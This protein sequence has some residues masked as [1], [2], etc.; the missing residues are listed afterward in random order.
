MASEAD[1][2]P[3]EAAIRAYVRE[4]FADTIEDLKRLVRI[5]SVSWPAFDHEP[6]QRTSAEIAEMLRETGIFDLVDVRRAP[7]DVQPEGATEVELGQPAV[8][9][10]RE[11]KNGRPTVLLYAHHDVQPPGDEQ[12][13]ES[14]AFEPNERNGRLYGRGAADDKAGVMSHVGAIRALAD[15]IAADGGDLDLGIALF[16]EG[17]EEWASQSFG[18]FLRENRDVLA[19]D[20]IIVADSGNWDEKTPALTVALR[21]AVAFNLR[22]RTL[23]H[24]SHSGMFGGAVPDAMMATVKLLSTLWDEDGAVA[25]SGLTSADIASPEYD[26]ARL[27]EESALLP[28]VSTIG[29]GEI[30]SRIWAQPAISITGIDAPSIENASNTLI[31]ATRVRVSARVAPGQDPNEAYAAI[32]Q[33]LEERAPF[34][35]ELEFEDAGLGQAFLVDTSGWAVSE[36]R[37]AMADAWGVDPV[38]MGAGGSIPF[39]AE[40]VDEFPNAEIL[41]TGVEDPDGRA[42]SPNES[43]HIEA[44]EKSVLTEALFLSR[45]NE[46]GE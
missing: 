21:G 37:G 9:A 4:N 33:H 8:V 44:F 6:L 23:G 12:E 29:R 20:A 32:R 28:G 38:D 40:L 14:P 43:L 46:R 18:T 26:E 7:V 10:R 5:P 15:T 1:K 34:G 17:E 31:P 22:V 19:A 25:V 11:A 42:H 36:V 35:A 24:A 16:I 41:V 27:R 45:L 39:I 30:L 13:W 3:R 2:H